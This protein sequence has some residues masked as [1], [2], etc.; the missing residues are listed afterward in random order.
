MASFE[1]RTNWQSSITTNYTSL[2]RSIQF[3]YPIKIQTFKIL[4]WRCL[5]D[6]LLDSLL[7]NT[8]IYISGIYLPSQVKNCKIEL[9]LSR[10]N[11]SCK[12]F[13]IFPEFNIFQIK[14]QITE[15]QRM[16]WGCTVIPY[17]LIVFISKIKIVLYLT[18]DNIHIYIIVYT[19]YIVL[20][21]NALNFYFSRYQLL[22]GYASVINS[23]C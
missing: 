18:A 14:F 1:R 4:S 9:R 8:F 13:A 17:T 23:N 2:K 21:I 12:F 19:T 22:F 6:Q 10:K 20:Y 16:F 15:V 11:L 3:V 5:T 7:W